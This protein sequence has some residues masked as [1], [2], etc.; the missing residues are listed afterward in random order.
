MMTRC[1]KGPGSARVD[2]AD[3]QPVGPDALKMIRP[4]ER[5][6]QLPTV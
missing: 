3:D 4:G 6:S 1:L 5:F 2:G